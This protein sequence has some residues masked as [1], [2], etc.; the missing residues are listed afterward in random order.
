MVMGTF[1]PY[2]ECNDQCDENVMILHHDIFISSFHCC[3]D[4]MLHLFLVNFALPNI[5]DVMKVQRF[6]VTSAL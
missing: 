2:G 5:H 4:V 3:N 1:I 6:N